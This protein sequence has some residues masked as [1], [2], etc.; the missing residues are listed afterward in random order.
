[1]IEITPLAWKTV[2]HS[3][4]FPCFIRGCRQEARHIAKIRYGNVVVQVCLCD[5]CLGKSA[6]MI[7]HDL[8]IM[9][10]EKLN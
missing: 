3:G 7:L 1:M 5:I 2:G 10:Q 4:N 9:S 8:G 6:A